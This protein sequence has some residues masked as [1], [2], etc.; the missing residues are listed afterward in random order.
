LDSAHQI[1][2]TSLLKEVLIPNE[3]YS[4]WRF[5]NCKIYYIFNYCEKTNRDMDKQMVPLDSEHQISIETIFDGF[6]TTFRRC[7][8]SKDVNC[9]MFGGA[10]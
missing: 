8:L 1:G 9:Y 3:G 5:K 10:F 2:L 7:Y 6:L 4:G